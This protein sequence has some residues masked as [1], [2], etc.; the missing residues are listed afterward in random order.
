MAQGGVPPEE[1][2]YIHDAKTGNAEKPN[3]LPKVM[4]RPGAGA[5]RLHGQN[6]RG[7]QRPDPA[8]RSCTIWIVR[9]GQR[10]LNSVRAWILRQGNLNE[11]C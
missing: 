8:C 6:G 2:A 11:G 1:I 3:C 5:F 7:N 9:G 10:I 4:E